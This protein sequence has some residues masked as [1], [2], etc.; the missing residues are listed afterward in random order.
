MSERDEIMRIWVEAGAE[1][2]YHEASQG[3]PWQSAGREVQENFRGIV[4]RIIETAHTAEL[5]HRSKQRD[6]LP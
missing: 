6:V 4:E 2:L 1:E 3:K 5:A